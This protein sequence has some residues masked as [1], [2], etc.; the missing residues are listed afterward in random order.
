MCFPSG[1]DGAKVAQDGAKV[2]DQAGP[3]EG[4]PGNDMRSQEEPGPAFS[5]R[6]VCKNLKNVSP[7]FWGKLRGG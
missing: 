2:R 3:G 5:F 1:E 6:E 4:G 7:Q